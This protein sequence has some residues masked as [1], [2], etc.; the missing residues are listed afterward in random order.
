MLPFCAYCGAPMRPAPL[1][2]GR[3]NQSPPRSSP[4]QQRRQDHGRW[5]VLV[6]SVLV[7]L[8]LGVVA[9]SSA[10]LLSLPASRQ[11]LEMVSIGNEPTMPAN[12]VSASQ[13]ASVPSAAAE[14]GVIPT[15][16]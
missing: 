13:P 14:A 2:G 4:R 7:V 11:S 8:V 10:G 15:L 9:A 3:A 12:V 5:L 6:G 16:T 1:A